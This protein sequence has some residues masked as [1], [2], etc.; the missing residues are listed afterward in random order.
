MT[1][2]KPSRTDSMWVMRMTWG[3]RSARLR[4]RSSTAPRCS[5]RLGGRFVH[6]TGDALFHV[7]AQA[8]DPVEAVPHRFDVGDEDDL[9]KAV[10][11][12][13]EQVEHRAAVLLVERA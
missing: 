9:G 11:E 13:A 3:K 5:L 8:D 6:G 4:S 10:G 1:R 7:V 2:S 12:I